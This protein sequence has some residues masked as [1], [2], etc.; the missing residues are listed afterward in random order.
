MLGEDGERLDCL[1]MEMWEVMVGPVHHDHMLPC[2]K[3]RLLFDLRVDQYVQTDIL[4]RGFQL[5]WVN[6]EMANRLYTA[7]LSV[8]VES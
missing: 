6:P 3:G 2:L 8:I 1:E 5:E 7:S 4:M